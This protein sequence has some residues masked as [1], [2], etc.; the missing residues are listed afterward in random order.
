MVINSFCATKKLLPNMLFS[1][2]SHFW[3]L[4]MTKVERTLFE[5]PSVAPELLLPVVVIT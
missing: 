3:P 5:E 2:T 1:L 4:F